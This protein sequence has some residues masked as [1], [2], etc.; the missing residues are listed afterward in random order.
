MLRP[1]FELR[2]MDVRQPFIRVYLDDNGAAV[3]VDDKNQRIAGPSKDHAEVIQ[4]AID[5]GGMINVKSGVYNISNRLSI[6]NKDVII[7]CEPGTA[8]KAVTPGITVVEFNKTI[9]KNAGLIGCT[10]DLNGLASVGLRLIDSWNTV[11]DRLKIINIGSDARGVEIVST[12][13]NYLSIGNYIRII[14]MSAYGTRPSGSVGVHM[15]S[16]AGTLPGTDLFLEILRAAALDTGVLIEGNNNVIIGQVI[17]SNINFDIR[18]VFNTLIV[19]SEFAQTKGIVIR[20]GAHA[21]II[22]LYY[23]SIEVEGTGRYVLLDPRS[24]KLIVGPSLSESQPIRLGISGIGYID[25]MSDG[26]KLMFKDVL[27]GKEL[28][29]I[30][31]TGDISVLEPGKGIILTSP[32]GSRFRVV[33]DDSGTLS[34]EPV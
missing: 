14:E 25:L 3:A 5:I 19:H 4:R 2:R 23:E 16:E 22:P 24:I 9:K 33:V 28:F 27:T 11:H 32:N 21:T 12:D 10:L 7:T 29:R 18:G 34:T 15:Y 8:L 6:G 17:S 26:T 20:D 1:T 13:N 30:N 31:N